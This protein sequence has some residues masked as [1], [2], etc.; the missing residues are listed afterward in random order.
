MFTITLFCGAPGSGKTTLSKQMAEEHG[1]DRLSFDEIGCY[2][3]CE[4][5]QPINATLRT[6][7][8]VIVDS[9]FT[10]IEWRKMILKSISDIPCKKLVVFM[11]TP[12]EEC[13]RRNAQRQHPLPDFIVSSIHH[14]FEPPTLD[15]GW[16][17]IIII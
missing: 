3:H 13:I 4:L 12:L 5:I 6:G 17:E 15:E 10:R 9:V 7:K 2:R 16:D 8:S 1:V 14:S 11:N